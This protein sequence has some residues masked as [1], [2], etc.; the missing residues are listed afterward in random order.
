MRSSWER[1][2]SFVLKALRNGGAR[3]HAVC[4]LVGSQPT[5]HAIWPRLPLRG[6]C[7]VTRRHTCSAPNCYC[8]G[9]F[10][11]LFVLYNHTISEFE[12]NLRDALVQT[13]QPIPSLSATTHMWKGKLVLGRTPEQSYGVSSRATPAKGTGSSPELGLLGSPS[14]VVGAPCAFLN[15]HI[16][17]ECGFSGLTGTSLSNALLSVV[18]FL[19]S[20]R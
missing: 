16:H 2:G 9:V 14:H 3:L 19:N 6:A 5:A 10:S 8:W 7:G 17:K 15:L 4:Y 11:F 18:S 13:P 1:P 12:G 20:Q